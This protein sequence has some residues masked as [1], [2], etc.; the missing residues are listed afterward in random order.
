M[1]VTAI[2][3]LLPALAILAALKDATSYTIPNWISLAL[4][5]GFVPA[6]LVTHLPLM[7]IGLSFA[8]ALGGLVLG[9]AMFALGWIGG[10]DAK[11]MAAASLWL[12][13]AGLP[14]FLI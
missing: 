3:L 1:L 5:A 9:M 11:F 4:L 14:T 8:I 12:G 2:L 13:W 10:G 6:A 7:V